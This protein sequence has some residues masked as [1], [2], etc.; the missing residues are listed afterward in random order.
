MLC[1]MYKNVEQMQFISILD[2]DDKRE[3]LNLK[4]GFSLLGL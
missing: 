1:L 3:K 4:R 2:P